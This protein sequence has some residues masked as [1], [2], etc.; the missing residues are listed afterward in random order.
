MVGVAP[1]IDKSIMGDQNAAPSVVN[2]PTQA[3]FANTP[4]GTGGRGTPIRP[5]TAAYIA[6]SSDRQVTGN[7]NT[8]QKNSGIVTKAMEYIFGW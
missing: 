1:C 2:T 5:L 6:A 3:S 7:A 8:P 4:T